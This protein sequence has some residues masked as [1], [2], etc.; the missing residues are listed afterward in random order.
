MKD[1]DLWS[2]QHFEKKS[3][4]RVHNAKPENFLPWEEQK[5]RYIQKKIEPLLD[6]YRESDHDWFKDFS[7][8]RGVMMHSSELIYSL[9]KLNPHIFVQQQVNFDSDWG[10]YAEVGGRVQYLS[11]C[12]KGFL[13][14]FSYSITDDRDLPVEEKRGW[15]TILVLLLFKGALTWD[16]VEANFGDPDDS[17]NSERWFAATKE[18]R[19]GEEDVWLRNQGNVAEPI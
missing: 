14:E 13:P 2:P 8:R 15:R 10:L 1:N 4:E 3:W 7:R 5:E 17:W 6:Q 12:P 9:Q 11:A 16:Q 18:I 19:F